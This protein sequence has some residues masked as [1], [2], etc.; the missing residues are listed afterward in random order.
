MSLFAGD[1]VE[2]RF[3]TAPGGAGLLDS[4]E[5][6]AAPIPEPSVLGLLAVGTAVLACKPDFGVSAGK[7]VRQQTKGSSTLQA[8]LVFMDSLHKSRSRREPISP[9][10]A[11]QW[12]SKSPAWWLR[13]PQVLEV[14]M[15][16]TSD[17]AW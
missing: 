11:F 1:T 9:P 15:C 4:I 10:A 8:K 12:G 14:C 16:W 5:F 13:P 2:L 6:S 17:G 3:T 7:G